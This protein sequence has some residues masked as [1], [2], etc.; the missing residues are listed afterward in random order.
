MEKPRRGPEKNRGLFFSEV[1]L[2]K[3]CTWSCLFYFIFL[4]ACFSISQTGGNLAVEKVTIISH[5]SG[6]YF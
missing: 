1:T 3:D 6:S 4:L 2:L 5:C